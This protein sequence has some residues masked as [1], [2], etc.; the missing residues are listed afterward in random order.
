TQYNWDEEP[1]HVGNTGVEGANRT[2]IYLAAL[3]PEK[4]GFRVWRCPL[5]DGKR[6]NEGGLMG[7]AS[8]EI[9]NVS[10]E[11]GV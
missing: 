11:S 2:P 8:H 1:T 3:D 9:R 6:T 7:L 4:K 5:C 10:G